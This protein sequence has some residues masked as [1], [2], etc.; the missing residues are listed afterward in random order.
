[1]KISIITPTHR[2]DFFAQT[3]ESVRAQTYEDWEW[4]VFV[5]HKSGSRERIM[6]VAK[7]VREIVGDDRRVRVEYGFGEYLGVGAVKHDAFAAANGDILVELDHDDLLVP[8]ALSEINKAFSDAE[9]GFVY[10]NWA[11]FDDRSFQRDGHQ[12]EP[13]YRREDTRPRWI[14]NGFDFYN[15]EIPIAGGPGT[16]TIYECVRAFPPSALAVSLIYWAPNHV[17]AWRASVYKEIG[18]HDAAY[19]VADDHELLTRT[20]CATKFKHID[21]AL[22]LYR[23]HESNTFNHARNEE[24]IALLT[25]QT[26]E[27]MLEKLILREC[28]VSG[29]AAFLIASPSSIPG[30]VLV[31]PIDQR[32]KV[33]G[34]TPVEISELRGFRDGSVGALMFN[35]SLQRHHAKDTVMERAWELLA[36]GGHLM[37]F[38]PSTDGRGAFMDPRNQS[39]WNEA[40]FWY[41]TRKLFHDA[42]YIHEADRARFRFKEVELKTYYPSDW[43]QKSLITH[44]KTHLVALKGDYRG[45][46]EATL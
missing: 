3:Y 37:G 6:D 8:T 19:R 45:P 41:W 40:S 31:Q 24:D 10:S 18:G 32:A 33:N 29:H 4:I 20:Y 26:K 22:Y 23:V 9:I 25:Y 27:R 14:A 38:T 11:D 42:L 34:W 43:H 1:M 5:N 46:G 7:R 21:K 2:P 15:E 30:S 35:E 12:G 39:Y 13:T 17:R 36:P 16:S 28:E 44:V